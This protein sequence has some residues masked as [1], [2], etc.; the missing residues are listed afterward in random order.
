MIAGINSFNTG[1]TQQC[2]HMQR[3]FYDNQGVVL[4]TLLSIE[5]D[6]W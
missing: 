4:K 3:I 1:D 5:T 2:N 6:L